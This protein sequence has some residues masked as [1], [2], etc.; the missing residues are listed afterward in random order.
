MEA[1]RAKINFD[2]SFYYGLI[3]FAFSLPLSRALD[4][5]FPL[6]FLALFFLEGNLQTKLRQISTSAWTKV[7]FIFIVYE[8]LS[9]LW[10][11]NIAT[12]LDFM[13]YYWQ[14]FAIFAIA[15]HVKKEQIPAIITAFIAGMFV[16]EILSYG[17]FFELWQ[18]HG[19]GKES[20]S[21]FM[22]HIDYSV[23]LAFTSLILLNRILSQRYSPKEKLIMVL[24]LAT[25][26]INLFINKGRTGQL[27]FLVSVIVAVVIHYR[28]SFKALILSSVLLGTIFFSAYHFSSQFQ[29][30]IAMVQKDIQKM[31]H[32]IYHSSIGRRVALLEVGGDII[33]REPLL[34]VGVGDWHEA[35]K[36][37]LLLDDHGFSERVKTYIPKFHF[38]NQYLQVAVQSGL[39]GLALLLLLLFYAIRLPIKEKELKELSLIFI[40]VYLISFVAEP[41]FMKQ[42]T[43]VLFRLYMGLFLA[44]SLNDF[45]KEKV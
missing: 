45:S 35:A 27:A 7:V 14:W 40:S 11:D 44:A 19:K 36:A 1:L 20:P 32:G 4:S 13:R 43:N 5:F 26:L 16:S 3:L 38:H 18:F 8:S 10:T 31:Q 9:L 22:H 15:L 25:I 12:G 23:F 6:Y 28:I 2:K 41:L 29:H 30:R 34:G 24:F 37:S 17:M 39:I 42:F 33:K 21:P